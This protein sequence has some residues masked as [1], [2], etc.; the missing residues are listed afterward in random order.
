MLQEDSMTLAEYEATRPVGEKK[1]DM[2]IA[3][4]RAYEDEKGQ[5]HVLVNRKLDGFECLPLAYMLGSNAL[6]MPKL[7][8]KK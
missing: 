6:M 3:V 8:E 1:L 5:I 4:I 2:G 7:G